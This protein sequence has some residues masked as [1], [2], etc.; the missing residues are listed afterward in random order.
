[1]FVLE[2]R[3]A[4][5]WVFSQAATDVDNRQLSSHA[6][7]E[8][9]QW[10]PK[11]SCLLLSWTQLCQ[12]METQKTRRG[13]NKLFM[14]KCGTRTSTLMPSWK[15]SGCHLRAPVSAGRRRW[16]PRLGCSPSVRERRV[17]GGICSH[18]LSPWGWCVWD[19]S[20]RP[21]PSTIFPLVAPENNRRSLE[22]KMWVQGSCW[23]Q[24]QETNPRFWEHHHLSMKAPWASPCLQS[25]P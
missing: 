25:R 7:W 1:M 13:K 19:C 21:R 12:I 2:K 16:I 5:L 4:S 15:A 20:A 22:V 9:R 3:Q 17:I 23:L 10:L 6:Q 18:V 14:F 11:H 8:K 24:F